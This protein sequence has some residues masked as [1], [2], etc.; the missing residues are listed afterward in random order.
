MSTG[1]VI[2]AAGGSSRLG[3]AKQLLPVAGEVL[4][5]RSVRM[6]LQSKASPIIVVLGAQASV[7]AAEIADLSAGIVIHSTW[8]DGIASSIVLGLNSLL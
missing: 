7:C 5:R 4:L 8:R 1:V 3:Q 2:L 6:A